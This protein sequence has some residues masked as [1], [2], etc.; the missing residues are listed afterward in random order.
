MR[1]TA[2]WRGCKVLHGSPR[3][4]VRGHAARPGSLNEPCSTPQHGGDRQ[5]PG[6]GAAAVHVQLPPGMPACFWYG[7]PNSASMMASRS[8]LTLQPSRPCSRCTADGA[9]QHRL[10][11]QWSCL[12]PPA[13]CQQR[14]VPSL[15][16]AEHASCSYRRHGS[17]LAA[18]AQHVGRPVLR[19]SWQQQRSSGWCQ[20]CW[21]S[22][23]SLPFRQPEGCRR[24]AAWRCSGMQCSCSRQPQPR[25]LPAR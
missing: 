21:R 24:H 9:R 10:W 14:W 6:E 15:S 3:L 7:Q 16:G 23:R 4:L 18:H 19:C 25:S 11:G 17:S 5:Q 2:T 1:N 12:P 8:K 22:A 20:I 13:C